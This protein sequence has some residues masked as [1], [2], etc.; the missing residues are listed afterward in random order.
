VVGRYLPLCRIN[1]ARLAI[2]RQNGRIPAESWE[3]SRP[4]PVVRKIYQL[5]PRHNLQKFMAGRPIHPFILKNFTQVNKKDNQS[6][7]WLWDCNFCPENNARGLSIEHRDNEDEEA[8]VE[9]DQRSAD[10]SPLDPAIEGHEIDA[11]KAYDFDELERVNRGFVPRSKLRLWCQLLATLIGIFRH[12]CCLRVS[13][14]L[15]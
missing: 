8:F 3:V 14:L 1:F 5:L 9:L 15:R 6:G 2:A 13:R 12:C 11:A 7:H 4:I 10:A